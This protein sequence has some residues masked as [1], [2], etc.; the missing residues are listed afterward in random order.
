MQSQT[1]SF[2]IKRPT[3]Q[4]NQARAS[5]TLVNCP[6]ATAA[7]AT[8]LSS[9]S[10]PTILTNCSVFTVPSYYAGSIPLLDLLNLL[11]YLAVL[12]DLF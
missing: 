3:K 7:T 5:A 4:L 10:V 9:Y 11:Y 12:T 2:N 1:Q 6:A 8:I